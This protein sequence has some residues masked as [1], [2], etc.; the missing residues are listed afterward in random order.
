LVAQALAGADAILE[1]PAREGREPTQKTKRPG[2]AEAQLSTGAS[3]SHQY[4]LAREILQIFKKSF[5]SSI[6]SNM[7]RHKPRDR[8][9]A[10]KVT[11]L[12]NA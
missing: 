3:V 9:A 6:F 12:H 2:I 1:G 4:V 10:A 8:A 7:R 11:N 5:Y